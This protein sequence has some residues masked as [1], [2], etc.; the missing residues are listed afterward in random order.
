MG[1]DGHVYVADLANCRVRRIS[2]AR[3]TAKRISCDARATDV[4]RPSGCAS[5]DPPTDALFD[6]ASSF[7]GNVEYNRGRNYSRRVMNCLGTPP[8]VTGLDSTGAT[9]GP[10]EGTEAV[11]ASIDEDATTN[12]DADV[13]I[14]INVDIN[15]N[16]RI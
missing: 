9:L 15:V 12:V 1:A 11:S 8:L 13:N 3:D 7:A 10:R 14:N 4:L 5:Y 16:V 2:A 6:K